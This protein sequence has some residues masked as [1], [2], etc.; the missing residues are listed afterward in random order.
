MELTNLYEAYLSSTGVT[1]DTRNIKDG[2]IFFA[3]KGE[4]FNGNQFAD[5]AL[6]KGARFAVVDE[7]AHYKDDGTYFLVENVLQTLQELAHYHRKQF[8]IPVIGITGSNGKTTTKELIREVLSSAY[9]VHCTVGNF[10]NHIGVPLTLLAMPLDTE[11]AIIEMGANHQKEIEFLCRIAHPNHGLVTN[12]GKAH[13]EGF[14]GFEGVIKGKGEMYVHLATHNGIAFVNREEA[15]L[16]EMASGC[17]EI[18]GYGSTIGL[19]VKNMGAHPFLEV[20]FGSDSGVLDIQSQLIGAYN[21]PNL[22][23]AITLGRYFN[24]SGDKIKQSIEQY[25][26]KNNRSQLI[27]KGTNRI[28]MDAY[29]ANPTSMSAAIRNFN[30]MNAAK[31]ILVIGD[32]LELGA[33]S[34]KEHESILQLTKGLDFNAVY[35]VGN[36][37]TQ[38]DDSPNSYKNI[39]DL[40]EVWDWTTHNDTAFLIKGSRGIRLEKLIS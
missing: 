6:E 35:T 12:V 20:T 33:G 26:P 11:I 40:K 27:R 28:I 10:N 31:K 34:E 37:F 24:V 21:F 8:N 30:K 15:H 1:T 32:M 2:S 38:V 9:N 3:L 14:G 22:L 13:L 23:T 18:I 39:N 29:N 25:E 4:R 19:G 7:E 5:T 17:R 16:S 36:E